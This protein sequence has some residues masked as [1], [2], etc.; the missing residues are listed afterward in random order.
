MRVPCLL[1]ELRGDRSLREV[2]EHSGVSRGTLSKI[3]R[4]QEFPLDKH[5]PALE[6]AYG[7]PASEW[8]PPAVLLLI[9]RDHG[10]DGE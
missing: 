2:E 3:E 5:V 6:Q 8:W 1:R 7:A 10:D 9:E 4:G